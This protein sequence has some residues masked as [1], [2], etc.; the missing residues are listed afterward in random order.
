MAAGAVS[1]GKVFGALALSFPLAY[2]VWQVKAMVLSMVSCCAALD[3]ACALSVWYE[4]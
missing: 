3:V 4:S 1:Q 2:V